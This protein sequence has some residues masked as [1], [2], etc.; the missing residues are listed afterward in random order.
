MRRH[1]TL[2]Y[3]RPRY[4]HS[5][6]SHLRLLPLAPS[7]AVAVG[8]HLRAGDACDGPRPLHERPPCAFSD[9][10]GW[11]HGWDARLS[12]WRRF[13]TPM[14]HQHRQRRRDAPP[15]GSPPAELLLST[16]SSR[17]YGE[18]AAIAHAAG[19]ASAHAFSFSRQQYGARDAFIE[20][21]SKRRAVDAAALIVEA[22]VDLGLLAQAHVLCAALSTLA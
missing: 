6:A 15:A 11:R 8:M 13:F 20:D 12:E 21:R 10:A 16:D 17:A 4:A 5:F 1:G 9:A 18:R 22:F 2:S 7:H 14:H 19:I 3:W